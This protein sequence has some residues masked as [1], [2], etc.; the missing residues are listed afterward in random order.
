MLSR[1][2]SY[3]SAFV[4]AV[5]VP[6]VCAAA[7]AL[8]LWGRESFGIFF[9][10]C[11]IKRITGFNCLSCGATRSTFALLHGDIAAAIYYNPLYIAFLGWLVYLY[12]RLVISLIVRPYRK[13]VLRLDWKW[14]AA[15][16]LLLAAFTIV[17]N[18]SFYQAIFY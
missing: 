2:K 8:V 18:L 15:V 13:Y 7:A 9:F 11:S 10:P 4:L 6:F 1:D 5:A 17:R 12:V 14:A 16:T 3:R